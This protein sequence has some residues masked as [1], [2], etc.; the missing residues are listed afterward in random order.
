MKNSKIFR[1]VC[2]GE[3]F[4]GEFDKKYKELSLCFWQI[5]RPYQK[6]TRDYG[7]MWRQFKQIVKYGTPYSDMVI[8][9]KKSIL[10]FKEWLDNC[11]VELNEEDEEIRKN[12]L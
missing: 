12:N 1:C 7:Y 5:N 6:Q 3:G 11:I 8:M 9:D 10:E 4:L 2:G